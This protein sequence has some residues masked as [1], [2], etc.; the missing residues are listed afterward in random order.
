[1]SAR[2][3]VTPADAR[4]AAGVLDNLNRKLSFHAEQWW[5]PDALRE[6]LPRIP[7]GESTAMVWTAIN[8]IS[9]MNDE[10]GHGDDSGYAPNAIRDRYE[11]RA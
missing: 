10:G 8:V 1:M 5:S 9:A 11:H 2:Y 3:G 4:T 7:E 6:I